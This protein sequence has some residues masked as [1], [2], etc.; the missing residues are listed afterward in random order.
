[1]PPI[2]FAANFLAGS[3]LTLV[4]PVSVLI[5]VAIWYVLAAMRTSGTQVSEVVEKIDQMVNP[6]P[7]EG[8]DPTDS[9]APAASPGPPVPP[10][11]AA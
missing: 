9:A 7:A 10:A 4:L 6:D 2:P 8:P 5:A 1:M 11:G 3:I